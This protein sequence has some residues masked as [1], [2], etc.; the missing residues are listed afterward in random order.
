MKRYAWLT[1]L[2]V[3]ALLGCLPFFKT[4][5]IINFLL[6]VFYWIGLTGCWNFMSGYTGYIDFGAVTYVG[7]GSYVA[8]VLTLHAGLP[9]LPAVLLAGL[10]SLVLALVVGWP[11]LKLRGAYFAI[12]TFALAEALK[13]VCEEWT[14]MTGGGSGMTYSLRLDDLT[15][16]W[17]YLASAAGVIAMTFFT[18]RSKMGYAMKAIHQDEHAATRVGINT[19]W[20]KI[21]AYGQS[22]FFMG[23]L[24]SLEASRLGYITPVDVFNVHIT[25]KMVIMS[26]LGG[27]GTVLGPVIGASF[28][29]VIE[30]VL[31]SSFLNWYLVFIGI[32]IILVIMFMP[33][34][35]SGTLS[36]RL[37]RI[38][39][40]S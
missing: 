16:Y 34:G 29:Q 31:G 20:I 3:V 26:L 25:I 19:H 5:Y 10:A 18:D 12:A 9:L 38:F 36:N 39:K 37:N 35:I 15:Y 21:R 24:G 4:G 22:A 6:V 30:E 8:G 32:I 23:L 28:L 14:S 17:I 1:G 11:T 7:V 27:M 33:S 13:Q 40:K 2:V